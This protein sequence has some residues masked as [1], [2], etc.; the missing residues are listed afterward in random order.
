MAEEE[1]K[2]ATGRAS[3]T[4]DTKACHLDE[5]DVLKLRIIRCNLFAQ[6]KLLL[7]LSDDP[8]AVDPTTISVV[9]VTPTTNVVAYLLIQHSCFFDY[10]TR[11]GDGPFFSKEILPG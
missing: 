7:V 4:N 11:V 1:V 10:V 9:M 5:I 6:K 2:T 3:E 8:L